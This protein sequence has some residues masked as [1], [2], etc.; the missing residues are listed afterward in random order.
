LITVVI[1]K[2]CQGE[3]LIPVLAT[4]DRTSHYHM[5]KNLIYPLGLTISLRV[6]S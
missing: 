6:V 2:L 3:V 4:I 5:F 1:G